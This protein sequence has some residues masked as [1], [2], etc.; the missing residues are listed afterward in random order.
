M[1]SRAMARPAVLPVPRFV[2]KM[3]FGEFAEEGLLASQKVEPTI[4]KE[5]RYQFQY[6]HLGHALTDLVG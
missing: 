1:V 4:L 5:D 3:V 6:T 2:L